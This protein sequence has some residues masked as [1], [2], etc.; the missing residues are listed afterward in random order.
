LKFLMSKVPLQF[1][2]SGFHIAD[3][4]LKVGTRRVVGAP[5]YG[6]QEAV[7]SIEQQVTSNYLLVASK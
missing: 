4:G 3:A 7:N 1:R 6:T 5:A 2:G